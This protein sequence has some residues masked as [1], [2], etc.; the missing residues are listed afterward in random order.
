MIIDNYLQAFNGLALLWLLTGGI[1]Y[2]FLYKFRQERTYWWLWVL[3]SFFS[4]GPIILLIANQSFPLDGDSSLLRMIVLLIIFTFIALYFHTLDLLNI[5]IPPLK[6]IS[7]F[8][9][10]LLLTF[11]EG[12]L[13]GNLEKYDTVIRTVTF[14]GSCVILIALAVKNLARTQRKVNYL[15]INLAKKFLIAV[16]ILF[17]IRIFYGVANPEYLIINPHEQVDF[18]FFLIRLLLVIFGGLS[19]VFLVSMQKYHLISINPLNK[20]SSTAAY[21]IAIALNERDE[22]I[23][24]LLKTNK[25]LAV[26]AISTSL[27]H[28]LNQP[29]SS[30]NVNLEILKRELST[31]AGNVEIDPETIDGIEKSIAR[32]TSIVRTVSNLSSHNELE[33]L[34]RSSSIKMV[35]NEIIQITS[36]NLEL[37]HIKVKVNIDDCEL[38][39]TKSELEQVILNI[40]SNAIQALKK[41]ISNQEKLIKIDGNRNGGLKYKITI[42]NN[43]GII[44]ESTAANLFK[45]LVNSTNGGL[46]IGLWLSKFI[47]EKNSATVQ[48]QAIEPSISCFM[49]TIPISKKTA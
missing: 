36:H 6:I 4:L 15:Q 24:S 42:S 19:L 45:I 47:L 5:R 3:T 30:L 31:K 35:I 34:N 29:L 43:G 46:G 23:N 18:V 12:L 49:I 33:H 38:A 11:P 14:H 16:A 41:D 10:G 40:I 39:I 8:T 28:E 48:Y 27:A 32:A 25:T 7:L 44:S 2:A 13:H 37:N 1:G 9:V 17:G 22:L 26:G 21:D 20:Y